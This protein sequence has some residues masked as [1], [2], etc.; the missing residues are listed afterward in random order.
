M[1]ERRGPAPCAVQESMGKVVFSQNELLYLPRTVVEGQAYLDLFHVI[2]HVVNN[3][4]HGVLEL[5]LIEQ[6]HAVVVDRDTGGL[7]TTDT[8]LQS[9]S[10]HQPPDKPTTSTSITPEPLTTAPF[11][12]ARSRFRM[13]NPEKAGNSGGADKLEASCTPP[14]PPAF[15]AHPLERSISPCWLP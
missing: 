4:L 2:I 1:C 5:Q 8:N 14:Y 3:I 6:F 15:C 9:E 13:N 7:S 12:T 10:R 11:D